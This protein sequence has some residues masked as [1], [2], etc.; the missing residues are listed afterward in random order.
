MTQV[1]AMKRYESGQ[2]SFKELRKWV[3]RG[4]VPDEGLLE[5]T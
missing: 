2:F 3:N 5:A 4:W 1:E